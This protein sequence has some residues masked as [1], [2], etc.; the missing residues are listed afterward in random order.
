MPDIALEK[1][2]RFDFY[3]LVKIVEILRGDKGCPWDRAQ[4]R[5][6]LKKTLIEESYELV[7]A[8]N[9]NDEEKICEETGDLLLQGAFY[10]ALSKEQG[11]YDGSDVLSGICTKLIMRHSHVFGGDKAKSAEEAL[12]IWNK[13]KQTEK[14]LQDPKSYVADVPKNL[15]ALLRAEKTLKRIKGFDASLNDKHVLVEKIQNTIKQIESNGAEDY[16]KKLLIYVVNLMS[17]E[18]FCAEDLAYDATDELIDFFSEIIAAIDG[19][20]TNKTRKMIDL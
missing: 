13:N 10:I 12:T 4:T 8:I 17:V 5:E 11:F 6:S 2:E 16:Y 18:G 15:P 9:K 1:R 14:N 19:E 20:A 3:D 7:D